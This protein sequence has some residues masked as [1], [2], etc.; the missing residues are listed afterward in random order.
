MLSYLK[1]F[2]STRFEKILCCK[3]LLQLSSNTYLML[4]E[5]WAKYS[6]KKDTNIFQKYFKVELELIH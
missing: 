6:N 1:S 4:R 3:Y 5:K 2:T